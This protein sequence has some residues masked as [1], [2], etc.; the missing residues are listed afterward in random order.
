LARHGSVYIKNQE[1]QY[2]LMNLL[3]AKFIRDDSVIDEH[4]GCEACAGGYK[5]AYLSHLLR[6]NEILGLRLATMHNLWQYQSL[7]EALQ[8]AG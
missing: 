4:C 2:S 5:R 7:M 6:S 8:Q 3:N 1:G